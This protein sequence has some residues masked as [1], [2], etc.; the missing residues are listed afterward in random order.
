PPLPLAAD[1]RYPCRGFDPEPNRV[2]DVY[3]AGTFLVFSSRVK[4]GDLGAPS[5]P[6]PPRPVVSQTMWQLRRPPF[7]A[8]CVNKPGPCAQL[9]TSAPNA[10]LRPLSVSAGRVLL[11]NNGVL[12]LPSASGATM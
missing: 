7:S 11:L 12:A 5:C 3:G 1:T 4:C 8:Q 9:T 2:G 10:T 6:G